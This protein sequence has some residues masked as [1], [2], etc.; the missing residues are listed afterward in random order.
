MTNLGERIVIAVERSGL[1]RSGLANVLGISRQ[2]VNNW[3]KGKNNPSTKNL[4]D[5]AAATGVRLE[6]LALDQGPMEKERANNGHTERVFDL[7][8]D[9]LE[10]VINGI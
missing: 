5:I 4:S 7:S 8:T 6:W 10:D 9:I 3:I 2:A 1:T